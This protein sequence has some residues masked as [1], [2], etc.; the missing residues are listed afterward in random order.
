MKSYVYKI[1]WPVERIP[2]TVS[3]I[4]GLRNAT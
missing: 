4:G 2:A 1:K 3:I